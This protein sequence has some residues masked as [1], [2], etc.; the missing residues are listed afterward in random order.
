M[1]AP[2]RFSELSPAWQELVRVCQALHFGVIRN[3]QFRGAN[4]LVKSA[5]VLVDDIQH[6]TSVIPRADLKNAS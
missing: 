2:K 3:L 4:P 1:N 6:P 5:Y